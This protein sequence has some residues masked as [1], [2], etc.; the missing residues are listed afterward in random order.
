MSAEVQPPP[1][2]E[3][4]GLAKTFPGQRA[5]AGVDLELRA[6]EI[7][8]LVGENGCGKSTFIKCLSGYHQPDA[9]G[10]MRVRGADVALPYGPGQAADLG[11]LFVHQDFGIVPSLT[12]MENIAL[13]TGF[14]T[15]RGAIRW[16]EQAARARH[17]LERLG[18]GDIPPDLPARH[19]SASSQAIVAIARSLAG[20]EDGA[21]LIVLDEPTAALP[22]AEVDILFDV[23]RRLADLG[24]ATLFVSH[25]L[26][27][28]FDLADRVT[29]LRDGRKVGTHDVADLDERRLVELIVGRDLQGLYPEPTPPP[30]SD[31]VLRIRG[32]AGVRLRDVSFDAHAGEIVG[33]A[34]LQGSGRSELLRLL[35]GAQRRTGGEVDL[36]GAPV[37]FATTRAGIRAG[38]A[39]VPEDRLNQGALG[40]MTVAEN[41][42]LPTVGRYFRQGVLRRGAERERTA[43]LIGEFNVQ[44]PDPNRLMGRLSGGNQQKAILAKWIETD[45]EVL[46]LDEPVQ[47]VDVGSKSEIWKIIEALVEERG[48]TVILTSS[49]FEDLQAICHRVLVLRDG[50]VVAELAA[51][52]NTVEHITNHAYLAEA[53]S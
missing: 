1:A 53:A 37:D 31:V 14:A 39:L 34:G 5:L 13:G 2:V 35:F 50:A 44:P 26:R 29:V 49:D 23:V 36:H 21:T 4:V 38:M 48:T 45:P 16:R 7:H 18:R 8:A 22:E 40:G 43:G 27:E 11:F 9:G 25:R 12:V 47:G 20:A 28:V 52:Q 51:A 30:R 46:L 6:G 10:A 24:V 3:I 33:I 19:L 32:L 41:I 17:E 42:S 15:R